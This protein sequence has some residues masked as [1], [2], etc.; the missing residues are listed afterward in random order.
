[1]PLVMAMMAVV[2]VPVVVAIM[3]V[4]AF[5]VMTA[6]MPVSMTVMV[7]VSWVDIAMLV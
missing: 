1:M 3:L 5:P 2:M 6:M 4:V 7:A